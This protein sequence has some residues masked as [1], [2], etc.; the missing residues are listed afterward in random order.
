MTNQIAVAVQDLQKAHEDFVQAVG[1]SR[2][3][4]NEMHSHISSLGV[5]WTGGAASAFGQSMNQWCGQFE[6]IIGQLEGMRARLEEVAQRYNATSNL[7]TEIA[8][9]AATRGLGI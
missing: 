7:T 4:L 5:A 6:N 1:T 8:S 3:R 9:G 2:S